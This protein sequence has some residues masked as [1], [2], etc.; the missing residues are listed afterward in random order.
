MSLFKNNIVLQAAGLTKIYGSG[1]IEVVAVRD[2][3]LSVSR[4]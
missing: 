4:G 2:V 1:H 3:S